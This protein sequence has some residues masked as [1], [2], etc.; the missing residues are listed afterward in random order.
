MNIQANLVPM[1]IDS[2]SRGERAYD[3]FSLLLKERIVFLGTKVDDVSANLVVAQLLYLNSIDQKSPINLYINSPG[4]VIYAGLAI[5]DTMQMI[6]A[7]VSTVAVGVTA[8]MG[9]AL[10]CAGAKGKRYALPHSTIHMHPTGGGAQGYTEDVR[11]ATREQERLQTQ[12]FHLMGKHTGHSW[13][14]IEAFFLR[15]KYLNVLEAKTFGI[16]DEVLGSTDDIIV[17]E[18]EGFKVSLVSPK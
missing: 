14:E 7:P 5:Y 2:N 18:K 9:T 13:E 10:L 11:I 15:D 4:G 6:Q 3:I 17:L 12:L 8:S 1:V 16:I